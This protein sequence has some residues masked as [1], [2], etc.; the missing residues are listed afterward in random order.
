[1]RTRTVMQPGNTYHRGP[2]DA[3]G[4]LSPPAFASCLFLTGDAFR[5]SDPNTTGAP[6]AGRSCFLTVREPL[7]SLRKP[8]CL[9]GKRGT[10]NL[11][12]DLRTVYPVRYRYRDRLRRGRKCIRTLRICTFSSFRIESSL[13]KFSNTLFLLS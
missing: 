9:P 3:S 5:S 11:Q 13:Y 8:P 7:R 12:A 1:M 6:L 10:P 4:R 2:R